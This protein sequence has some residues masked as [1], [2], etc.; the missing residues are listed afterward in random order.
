MTAIRVG[1]AP[2][3]WNNSDVPE[4]RERTPFPRI[5]DEMAAAGYAGTEHDRQFPDDPEALREALAARGLEL[6]ASYQWVRFSA[7]QGI[8]DDLDS[9]DAIL[10]MLEA[11]GCATLVVADAM[12][13]QRRALAGRVPSDGSA[14]LDA[15]GWER[16]QTNLTR[17]AERAGQRGIRT[18]YHNHVGS[19]VESPSECARLVELLPKTGA[20]LCFDTG[21]YAYGGGDATEFVREHSNLIGHL[22]LK[23]VNPDMLA[24]ARSAGWS[25]T[26]ALRKVIFCPFG[27][28]LVNIPAIVQALREASFDGWIVVEQDTCLGDPTKRAAA[29]R[30]YL[31]S[32]CGI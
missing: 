15:A 24:Q 19:Y 2:V 7:E 27:D 29:N 8:E 10:D 17:V 32:T 14:G 26:D 22:H 3:N 30:G 5:L 18:T 6:C 31:R 11:V 4:L 20:T 1:T 21:H 13:S 23:D 12:T 25:F 9:V 16:L 28:G